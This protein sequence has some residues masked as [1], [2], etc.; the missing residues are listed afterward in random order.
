MFKLIIKNFQENKKR[1]EREAVVKELYALR[2]DQRMH[3]YCAMGRYRKDRDEIYQKLIFWMDEFEEVVC[4]PWMQKW[5]ELD[6]EL[7]TELN[8]KILQRQPLSI[9]QSKDPWSSEVKNLI[10]K[11]QF[12][13]ATKLLE[14]ERFEWRKN[15]DN[16]IYQI[17][18]LFSKYKSS[19][20]SQEI[21][22]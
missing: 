6:M 12:A 5:D 9:F 13:E 20:Q 14:T 21:S 16:L 10:E 17:E 1:K 8:H 7:F 22:Q 4:V 2:T 18:R 15:A 11:E 19:T 3:C